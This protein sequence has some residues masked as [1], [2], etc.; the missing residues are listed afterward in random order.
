MVFTENSE[1]CFLSRRQQHDHT[2]R[3]LVVSAAESDCGL[4]RSQSVVFAVGDGIVTEQKTTNFRLTPVQKVLS[5]R[6]FVLRSLGRLGWL[7]GCLPPLCPAAVAGPHVGEEG[8]D[9]SNRR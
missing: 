5:E 1:S 9:G 6:G 2:S 8:G 7:G 4:T 3:D